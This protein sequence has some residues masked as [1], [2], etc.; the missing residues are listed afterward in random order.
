MEASVIYYVGAK[1]A[2]ASSIKLCVCTETQQIKFHSTIIY[3]RR[4]FP[5]KPAQ[6]FPLILEPPFSWDTFD[7]ITVLRFNNQRLFE[8]HIELRNAGASWDY[9]TFQAHIS[10]GKI[11]TS[12]V[13]NFPIVLEH[14][15]YSTWHE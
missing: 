5:Y 1:V 4:W 10:F 15:Y 3:S 12:A 7:G 8:R 14:E 9:P 11:P 13:P 2:E 6:F